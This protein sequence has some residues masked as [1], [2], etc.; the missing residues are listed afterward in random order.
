[1]HLKTFSDIGINDLLLVGGKAASLAKLTQSGIPVPDGFVV[2]T[3]VNEAGLNDGLI[4]EILQQFDNLGATRVA[5]RSSAVAEDSSAASWAGQLESFLNVGRGD[6]IK[7]IQDCWNSIKSERATAYIMSKGIGL[8]DQA[9]AV[10]VQAMVDSEA[11]G[12]AFT[13]NPTTNNPDEM[14][15]EGGWGL[16]ESVVQGEITPEATTL[17]KKNLIVISKTLA[18]QEEMLVYG[19]SGT[20]KV[21]VPNVKEMLTDN[22]VKILAA[23]VIKVEDLYHKPMDVEWAYADGNFYIVQARPITTLS[24]N[25][26][27]TEVGKSKVQII[28]NGK[29]GSAGFAS[30]VARV[31]TNFSQIGQV[32]KGEIL[33][34]VRTTP[35]YVEAFTKVKGIVTDI[36]G[37][38]SHAAIVSRELGIPAVVDTGNGT[39]TIKT[40]DIIT[41]NGSTGEVYKGEVKGLESHSK[42]PKYHIEKTGN[43]IDDLLNSMIGVF[44]DVRDLWPMPPVN[45][46]P[47][48]DVDQALSTY[49]KLKELV[50]GGMPFKDIAKLFDRAEQVRYLLINTGPAS[51]KTAHN[52]KIADITIED[53]VK[54]TEWCIQIIKE[55][56]QE[57]PLCLDGK[58][59]YWPQEKVD[60]FVSNYSWQEVTDEYREAVDKLSIN[61]YSMNWAFYWNY[62][63]AAGYDIHGPYRP[64]DFEGSQLIIKDYFNPA[65][66]ELWSLAKDVPFKSAMLAQVYKY[67]DIKISF[68]NRIVNQGDLA[69]N[70]SHFVFIIDGK[71]VTDIKTIRNLAQMAAEIT[72]RQTDYINAME[73]MDVARMGAKLSFYIHKDFYMHFGKDWYPEADIEATIKALG[74]EFIDRD[75]PKEDRTPELRREI[76]DPRNYTSA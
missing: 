42:E 20:I 57:D 43:E 28:A 24:T 26:S 40:G 6:L 74:R 29:V 53:Q 60:E 41:V 9:V 4:Q 35:D 39:E 36:G 69:G 50:E 65:P 48:F 67:T 17:D 5:V 55:L 16:G 19:E 58:N 18:R 22:Q 54:F 47:Y 59:I 38:T 23:L 64:K 11:A 72:K 21:P 3:E 71:H 63:G 51:L 75:P 14:V 32:Q 27:T 76:L 37:A 15:I 33:V 52:L 13:V 66:T 44:V 34:S 46:F 68:G 56:T 7:R 31:I 45:L 70:N 49:Q 8:E 61:L 30:G 10:I 25:Q 12:V 73:K 1:V 62:Y 2:T